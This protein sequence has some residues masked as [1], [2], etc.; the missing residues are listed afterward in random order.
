MMGQQRKI[1]VGVIF[2]GRSGEHDVSLRS[3][4][5]VMGA[6]DSE[7]FEVVPIGSTREGRWLAGGDAL[8]RL[9]SGSELAR[10]EG[11]AGDG[12]EEATTGS[13]LAVAAT[14]TPPIFGSPQGAGGGSLD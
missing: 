9:E 3:A 4:R 2:G 14:P 8:A 6:L 11:R 1:R 7:R 5:A 12:A 13:E 10:L